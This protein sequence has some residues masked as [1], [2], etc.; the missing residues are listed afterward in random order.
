MQTFGVDPHINPD[1]LVGA[2]A[3]FGVDLTGKKSSSVGGNVPAALQE[4]A[5]KMMHFFTHSL[6]RAQT[7]RNQRSQGSG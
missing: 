1:D 7:L 3:G 2:G 6:T 4:E 5:L